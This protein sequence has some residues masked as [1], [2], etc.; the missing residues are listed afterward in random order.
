VSEQGNRRIDR[1]RRP[2]FV[3]GLE[4]LSLDELRARRDE[5]LAERE[6]LSFLRRLVQGRAEILRAELEHRDAGR[7]AAPLVERLASILGIEGQGPSR[8]EAVKVGLPEEEMLLARRRVERL[9]A[10]TGLSDPTQLDDERLS[11]AVDLLVAEEHEVSETRAGV[12]EV[13]DRPQL[14]A[15]ASDAWGTCRRHSVD[16]TGRPGERGGG[17]EV[18][19][20]DLWR[21]PAPRE[22]L[23]PHRPGPVD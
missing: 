9:V 2:D 6:Y 16:T 18:G 7:T 14:S 5:C 8:G 19:P 13:L 20:K 22:R 21:S 11:Q 12:L 3:E 15:A 1:I 17:A 23:I 4:A 10:D